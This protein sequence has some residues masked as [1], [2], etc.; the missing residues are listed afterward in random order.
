M[1]SGFHHEV[2]EDCTLIGYHAASS[3]SYLVTFWDNVSVP[4]LRVK[5]PKMLVRYYHYSLRKS[6]EE[7]SSFEVTLF[8][9]CHT[10]LMS[11]ANST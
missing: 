8:I 1:I 2:E 9:L 3:S 7:H 6:P 5:G 4:S 10:S 11:I